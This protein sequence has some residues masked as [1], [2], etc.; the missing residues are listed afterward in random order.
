MK[1][2]YKTKW[3]AR[4]G[5]GVFFMMPIRVRLMSDMLKK[6]II[7]VPLYYDSKGRFYPLPRKDARM[8]SL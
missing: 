1:Y 3:A 2:D 4:I 8:V 5:D 6:P 7:G